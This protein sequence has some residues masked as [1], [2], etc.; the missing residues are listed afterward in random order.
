MKERAYPKQVT[1]EGDVERYGGMKIR[2]DE[3]NFAA[4]DK[5]E[6]RKAKVLMVANSDFAHTSNSLFWSDVI[7]LAAIDLDLIQSVSM[8]IG[9]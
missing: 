3:T 2:K 1:Q 6:M 5:V 9:V 4:H 7:I 8:A